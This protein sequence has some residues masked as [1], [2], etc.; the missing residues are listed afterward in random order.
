M[1]IDIVTSVLASIILISGTYV[2]RK[3][4]KWI[5]GKIMGDKIDVDKIRNLENVQLSI[6]DYAILNNPMI[7]NKNSVVYFPVVPT[8]NPNVIH[9]LFAFYLKEL[10]KAG[11]K[12]HM[13]IFDLY[14]QKKDNIQNESDESADVANFV[15]FFKR[16]VG[17]ESRG[18]KIIYESSFV[19]NKKKSKLAFESFL[20]KSSK[21]TVESI[22]EIQK[23]KPISDNERFSRYMKPILNMTYLSLTTPHKSN[24]G[25]TLSGYDEKVL[26]DCYKEMFQNSENCKLC[27]LYIPTIEHTEVRTSQS[28]SYLYNKR[29]II[30]NKVKDNFSNTII[31]ESS[32]I[33]IILKILVFLDNKTIKYKSGL[34]NVEITSW[35]NLKVKI[36]DLSRKELEEDLNSLFESI[37][38]EISKIC[39]NCNPRANE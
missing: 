38:L 15:S 26:W 37:A 20:E 31:P 1:L 33:S 6:E 27:N 23:N 12:I 17:P 39:S 13:F 28:I 19:K 29:E 22:K 5:Q 4:W 9:L 7:L 30:K 32:E 34:D 16:R 3:I 10:L 21:L 14:C 35:E 25:F 18:I 2:F 36:N 8:N 11:L 24:Y